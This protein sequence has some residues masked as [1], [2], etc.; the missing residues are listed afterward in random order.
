M[1]GGLLDCERNFFVCFKLIERF[2]CVWE[3]PDRAQVVNIL[4]A[5]LLILHNSLIF[6]GFC[7]VCLALLNY[8]D[9]VV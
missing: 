1:L 2:V 8:S 7:V 6:A 5:D 4:I 9:A 3:S